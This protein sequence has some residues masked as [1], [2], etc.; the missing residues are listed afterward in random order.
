MCRFG[1]YLSA[2]FFY[3]LATTNIVH[4]GPAPS[5]ADQM[6][7]WAP[8]GNCDPG[9]N[10]INVELRRDFFSF[11]TVACPTPGSL[12]QD[13]GAQVSATFDELA[14]QT[15]ASLDGVVALLIRHYFSGGLGLPGDTSPTGLAFGPFVQFDGTN[16]FESATSPSKTTE[17]VTAGGVAQIGFNNV[18]GLG[19][20]NFRLRAGEIDAPSAA[21]VSNTVVAEWIPYYAFSRDQFQ[22]SPIVFRVIPEVILQYDRLVSGPN[23]YVLFADNNYALRIGPEV[24]L[25]IWVAHSS[26]PILSK[27]LFTVTYHASNET[28]TGREFSWVQAGLTYNLTDHFGLS[29][30]YGYGNSE[31]TANNTS[32]IKLGLSGKL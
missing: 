3:V 13:Q 11:D 22:L 25:R 21:I 28:Y 2:L 30:S 14:K 26:D 12:S 9:K 27:M 31:I 16:Y 18:F 23:K 20:D 29:A 10:S 17:T 32:Q 7:N 4:A 8:W 24:Q 6:S 1:G 19:E 5:T 15:S